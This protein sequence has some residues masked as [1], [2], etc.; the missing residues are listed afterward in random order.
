[1]VFENKERLWLNPLIGLS[2]VW[3]N[4]KLGSDGQGNYLYAGNRLYFSSK[5]T[6]S[7]DLRGGV[8]FWRGF[9][10]ETPPAWFFG[11]G[12]TIHKDVD[13]AKAGKPLFAPPEVGLIGNAPLS[14]I[15]G[16]VM[17][18]MR[19][20]KGI[21]LAP[22]G[23]YGAETGS[24][25]YSAASGLGAE[26]RLFGDDKNAGLNPYAGFQHYWLHQF[27]GTGKG[28]SFYF[29]ARLYL[30][31]YIALDGNTGPVFWKED[32]PEDKNLKDWVAQI[33]FTVSFGKVRE[34]K[35][36]SGAVLIQKNEWGKSPYDQKANGRLDEKGLHRYDGEVRVYAAD[37]FKAGTVIDTVIDTVIV[38]DSS[39]CPTSAGDLTDL[40]FYTLNLDFD[41]AMDPFNTQAGLLSEAKGRDKDIFIAI[42]FNKKHTVVSNL[43]ET[44][45]FFHFVDLDNCQYFGYRW[46]ANRSRQP[47]YEQHDAL[48]IIGDNYKELYWGN[49]NEFVKPVSWLDKKNVMDFINGSSMQDKIL[50]VLSR[51]ITEEDSLFVSAPTPE[52]SLKLISKNFR[53]GYVKYPQSTIAKLEGFLYYRYKS[54]GAAVMYCADRNSNGLFVKARDT[55]WMGFDSIPPGI[56]S[57]A[58]VR[59]DPVDDFSFS[60]HV[61]MKGILSQSLALD[62]F[63]ECD[64]E[65][66]ALH[67]QI[68][69]DSVLSRLRANPGLT[70]SICG[71]TDATRMTD[72][73]FM[74]N[75]GQMDLRDSIREDRAQKHL[76]EARAQHVKNYLTRIGIR[77]E[78]IKETKGMGIKWPYRNRMP[79][80]RCVII[81]FID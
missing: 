34:N 67:E 24:N 3:V 18:P 2:Y 69:K 79:E 8:A 30:T 81:E 27:P 56:D 28:F 61:K 41:L 15:S 58:I 11:G 35:D 38:I 57:E 36:L 78:Q 46:D 19:F 76:S 40:K 52:D 21:S 60:N 33:G 5:R 39:K 44:N 13:F 4:P 23:S 66:S 43:N 72:T 32:T 51:Q 29:G 12:L 31:D 75:G 63:V 64:S 71:Y 80:D 16:K 25:P 17:F 48:G 9:D 55:R 1:M 74:M 20:W 70:I 42:L 54:L 26:I 53:I 62:Q 47:E 59:F 50:Q 45:T 37:S 10:E 6:L 7:L 49:F 65:P 77:D 73:C 68:L 14:L 22:F